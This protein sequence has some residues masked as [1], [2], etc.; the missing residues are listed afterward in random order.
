MTLFRNPIDI[1][2]SYRESG[3]YFLICCRN[4]SAEKNEPKKRG[5]PHAR[6][7]ARA[8]DKTHILYIKSMARELVVLTL[9]QK[10]TALVRK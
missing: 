7:R 5:G 3:L 9:K 2:K 10:S 6:F 1:E 4:P 8:P